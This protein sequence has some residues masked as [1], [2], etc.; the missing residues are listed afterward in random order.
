MRTGRGGVQRWAKR[1]QVIE[2]AGRKFIRTFCDYISR[3]A[4]RVYGFRRKNVQSGTHYRSFERP[5][6]N[7]CVFIMSDVPGKN[8]GFSG[9]IG[10]FRPLYCLTVPC[11]QISAKLCDY[12]GRY[13]VSVRPSTGLPARVEVWLRNGSGGNQRRDE[14][15]AAGVSS[16]TRWMGTLARPGNT[17]PRYSRTGSFIRRQLS[18]TDRMAATFGP[19]C[20]L[21]RWIQFFRPRATPRIEFSARLLLSSSS[22]CSRNRV[23]LC[24]SDSV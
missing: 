21:P 16:P 15:H 20:S 22:G 23:S 5:G 3:L 14:A 18:M 6:T 17:E 9:G 13:K 2:L 4:R 1:A 12:Y 10:I 7:A 24:H 11:D 8:F 19:A